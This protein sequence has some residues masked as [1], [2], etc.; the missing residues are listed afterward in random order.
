MAD[1][2]N[3]DKSKHPMAT[4]EGKG[5][6][7]VSKGGRGTTSQKDAKEKTKAA[8]RKY[9]DDPARDIAEYGGL[10]ETAEQKEVRGAKANIPHATGFANKERKNT[11]HHLRHAREMGYKNQDEYERAGIEF[12]N[13]NRGKLYYSEKRKRYC[14]Y[15][16]RTNEFVSVTNG[17]MHTYML[18]NKKEFEKTKQQ[19][20]LNENWES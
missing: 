14:K 16:F 1:T 13:S 20:K 7:F 4:I 8:I 6:R 10:V 9:S 15:D 2:Q 19:E 18:K 3:F 12:F 5:N 17:I 11:K